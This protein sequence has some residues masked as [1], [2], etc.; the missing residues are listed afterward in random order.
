MKIL[1]VDDDPDLL[2]VTAYAM[3]R[4]GFT[5]L[6]AADGEQALRSWRADLPDVVVLDVGLP[7]LNGFQI[8]LIMRQNVD[9]P[10]IILSARTDED[11]I[12]QGFRAGADDYIT[13]P[14]SPRQLAMRIR[15]V[16]RRAARSEALG[17]QQDLRFG[18][19]T[20]EVESH[21]VR[22][23]DQSIRLTPTE[24]RLL[25]MLANNPGRVISGARLLTYAWGYDTDDPSLLKTHFSHLRKK[26]APL[27]P[28]AIA[29]QSIP[30]VGYRLSW[31]NGVGETA[32]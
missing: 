14:F 30:R 31:L 21:E 8:C 7:K 32:S 19:L 18:D 5:V 9:T 4:E 17:R 26:L 13:K 22:R 15:A 16:A 6:L 28:G 12:V 3:R 11:H 10:V 2:D 25:Y 20:I 24:F 1:L 29:I 27:L 23:G